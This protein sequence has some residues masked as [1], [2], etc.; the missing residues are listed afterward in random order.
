MSD[1]MKRA[2]KISAFLLMFSLVGL[3]SCSI[4][5]NDVYPDQPVKVEDINGEYFGRLITVQGRMQSGVNTTFTVKEDIMAFKALPV[6]E[7]VGSV[8]EDEVAKAEAIKA[9]GD[10]KYNVDFT[11]S[12]HPTNTAVLLVFTPKPLELEI[13]VEGVSKK[14]VATFKA[15]RKGV[16]TSNRINSLKFELSVDKLTVDGVDLSNFEPIKYVFPQAIKK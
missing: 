12:L 7:I 13:P 4:D 2:K 1:K 3:A 15:E 14:V 10:V 8:V 5:D 6:R 9:I 11:A 16:Y